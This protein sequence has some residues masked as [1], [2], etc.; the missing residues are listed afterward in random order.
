M[1]MLNHA[2][3]GAWL[4]ASSSDWVTLIS[5]FHFEPARAN[6]KQGATN[7]TYSNHDRCFVDRNLPLVVVLGKCGGVSRFLEG[8][9]NP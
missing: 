8:G 5:L 9:G 2:A 6:L 1:A 4:E 3:F 7:V